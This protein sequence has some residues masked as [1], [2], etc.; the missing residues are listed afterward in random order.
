MQKRELYRPIN[1]KYE[2]EKI[3]AKMRK[4]MIRCPKCNAV[5]E[6]EMWNKLEMPYDE[7][8]KEAQKVSHACCN[9]YGRSAQETV[10]LLDMYTDSHMEETMDR[11]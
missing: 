10:N 8:Q 6:M 5:L 9:M 11:K 4:Q 2:G 7:N 3:M 1:E